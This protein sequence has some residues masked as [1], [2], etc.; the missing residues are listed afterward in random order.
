M[1][2][3]ALVPG[4]KI[5]VDGVGDGENRVVAQTITFSGDDLQAA[6]AIPSWLAPTQEAVEPNQQN[7]AANQVQIAATGEKSLPMGADSSQPARNSG[8]CEALRPAYSV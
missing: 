4:L 2:T 8:D 5:S 1:S 7:I 6:E 3:T